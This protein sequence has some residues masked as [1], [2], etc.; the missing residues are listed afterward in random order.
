M[1]YQGKQV[2]SGFVQKN[3]QKKS[4]FAPPK[5]PELAQN[6]TVPSAT[7]D[8]AK[9]QP[10]QPGEMIANVMRS[11]GME[12]PI[13]PLPSEGGVQLQETKQTET[14]AEQP[15]AKQLLAPP[16]RDHPLATAPRTDGKQLLVPK[17][18]DGPYRPPEN[19]LLAP[20]RP[21][22]HMDG[23]VQT[24]L[25]IGR[26]NDRY[27][28]E[29][30]RVAAAVVQQI[31]R[32]APFSQA[33][34]EVVQSK[35]KEDEEELNRK[36]MVQRRDVIGGGETS[37]ELERAINR[38]RGGGQS[39]DA[40]LQQSMGQAMGADFSQVRVHTDVQADRLNQ[41]LQA[42]AF[43]TGQDVFFRQGAYQPGN[44]GG[45]E[46]IAHELTHVVQQNSEAVEGKVQ[47]QVFLKDKDIET[48]HSEEA[49]GCMMVQA[50]TQAQ[51][52]QRTLSKEGEEDKS[53]KETGK[54]DYQ[55]KW[56]LTESEKD[57][58]I[59]QH[60]T[61]TEVS[62]VKE[63]KNEYWEAWKVQ[64]YEVYD[65]NGNKGM[66]KDQW[67]G[68]AEHIDG[69]TVTIHMKGV[70]YFTTED[71]SKV[72]KV[73]KSSQAGT[74]YYSQSEPT[75]DKKRQFEHEKKL[76]WK[77]KQEWTIEELIRDQIANFA[78][79][80]EFPAEFEEEGWEKGGDN[81]KDLLKEM[82]DKMDETGG[83]LELKIED[84]EKQARALF[85]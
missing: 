46:L 7:T 17:R 61:R 75:V 85:K 4:L 3:G 65:G 37:T 74:L 36:P 69:N 16:C 26:P 53:N 79:L 66:N 50:E 15:Q 22:S 84:L 64:N 31:N 21:R 18:E 43:T 13:Y 80:K 56:K 8:G 67:L 1:A 28:Q 6:V 55:F 30:D 27:E 40:G 77:Q 14:Q 20:P 29:A 45:Q 32:P 12:Q 41:S 52:V 34:G 62:N 68:S 57:G 59:I 81:W 19:Q 11:M 73:N 49:S 47:T 25:T 58:Y 63:E 33:Q 54:L 60:I 72:M 10:P 51:M 35:E 76:E 42:K 48:H 71:I 2:S 39:L 5:F 24:K 44:R 70:V 38:A 78:E 83:K 82:K 9:Y 23:V